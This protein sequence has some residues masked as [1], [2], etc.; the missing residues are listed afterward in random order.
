MGLI[1]EIPGFGWTAALQGTPLFI[2]FT[3]FAL[4]ILFLV[5]AGRS[6]ML[7]WEL[8]KITKEVRT[9]G[10]QARLLKVFAFE[11]KA[12][13]KHLWSEYKDTLHHL[14]RKDGALEYRATLPAE[15]FFSKETLVDNR[16][17]VWNDFFRHLPGILTGLGIIGTFAGLIV[18]LEG[19]SPSEDA[20]TARASLSSLL[21]GVQEAFHLS[22]FA[23]TSAIIVTFLEKSSLAWAYKNVENLTHAIDT[24][25]DAG[26]G[27][28][29]LA[30][31]VEAGE[32]NT[33]QTGDLKD[34]L[35]NDLRTLLGEL[36]ERQIE[37]QKASSIELGHVIRGSMGEVKSS[38]SD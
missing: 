33:A 25:Y 23:I 32:A 17:L 8:G 30:R 10:R 1:G 12:P 11:T 34:A 16:V 4:V 37:A 38:L 20:G 9:Q 5:V 6:L 26:A 15:A 7:A 29:Y 3:I 36:T 13:Y 19:F 35:V 2:F 14:K 27:E 28:E 31:L 22:A 24:L 18:G 21:H